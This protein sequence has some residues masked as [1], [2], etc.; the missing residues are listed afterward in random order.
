MRSYD[1]VRYSWNKDDTVQ[2]K[3]HPGLKDYVDVVP[4]DKIDIYLEQRRPPEAVQ[5]KMVLSGL[6]EKLRS[7]GLPEAA[8]RLQVVCSKI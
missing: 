1:R 5:T 2:G 4:K 8:Q 7:K 6:V 3:A